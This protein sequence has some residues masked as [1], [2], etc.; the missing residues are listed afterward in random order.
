MIKT[1]LASGIIHY[2]FPPKKDED[3]YG[4]NILAI[5]HEDKAVLIDTAFEDEARQVLDDLSANGIML[6]R[7][8]IS[9][10][11]N[12]HMEGLKLLP[13]IPVYGSSRFQDT[14]DM[15]TPK[16]DHKYFTPSIIVDEP[17][18]LE[19][20]NHTLEIIPSPGHSVCTVLVKIN[21][22][23]LHVA[24]EIIY[25]NEGQPLLPSI[26][27]RGDIKRQ[28]ESWGNIKDYHSFTIIPGHGVV[29]EGSELHKDLKNRSA[30]AEAILGAANEPI[31]YEEAVKNCDC[32]YLHSNWFDHLAE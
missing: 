6:D 21:N 26:E 1:E 30:Y 24:D 29:L 4:Y 32:T 7:I 17:M 2:M 14:L 12:D 11:H 18:V 15:W 9:H 5:I 19:L 28:L 20:G 8:I 27:S 31:T 22:Q 10:F 3:H 16:E 25:S 23:F 13:K